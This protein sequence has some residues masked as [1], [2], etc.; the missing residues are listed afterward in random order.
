MQFFR[1]RY[2]E[3]NISPNF[4]PPHTITNQYHFFREVK[5]SVFKL[6]SMMSS[7][8]FAALL[9]PVR[10]TG[11]VENRSGP[12]FFLCIVQWLTHF[13]AS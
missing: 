1:H 10:H 13:P 8:F 2:N 5:I 12:I 7:G 11:K 9:I 3:W 6:A 4:T